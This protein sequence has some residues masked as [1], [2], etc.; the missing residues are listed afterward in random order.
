MA[1][2]I[3]YRWDDANAPVARGERRSLCDILH[4]CLVTGYGAKAGAGWTREYVNATFDKAAFRNNPATGTG[5]YLQVDGAGAANAYQSKIMGYESM[6]DEST[7]LFPFSTAALSPFQVSNAANTTARPWVLVADDRFFYFTVWINNTT[8]PANSD[9]IKSDILF[10]DI[11]KWY[12]SDAYACLL[13]IG[14]GYYGAGLTLS[15]PNA[16]TGSYSNMPRKI[17]GVAAPIKPAYIIGG[18]PG[19]NSVPGQ[20][21][22]AWNSG[23]QVLISRPHINNGEAYTFRGWVPGLYYPC[24]P[25]TAFSQLSTLTVDSKNYLVINGNLNGSSS[26]G[27]FFISLDD[28]RA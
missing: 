12:P 13:D 16:T 21:G 3:V 18:G 1:A 8:T 17:S 22:M 2:P 19:T 26:G 28:W 14:P 5:F 10:G 20:Y 11:V 25:Y 4:A 6:T 7:G 27:G 9:L 23:D 24:H 15:S